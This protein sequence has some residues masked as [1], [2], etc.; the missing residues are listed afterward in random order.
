MIPS[1]CQYRSD[2]DGQSTCRLLADFF[3]TERRDLTECSFEMCQSCCK[4]RIPSP[5]ALNSSVASLLLLAS[6]KVIEEGGISTCDLTRAEHLQN[7]ALK[8]ITVVGESE[9]PSPSKKTNYQGSCFYLG[10]LLGERKCESCVGNIRQ[11]EFE[12]HHEG[13]ESTVIRDC[14]NCS[15]YEPGLGRGGINSWAVG[16]TTAPRREPNLP[17]MLQSLKKA[18]W[19]EARIFAEPGSEVVEEGGFTVTQRRETMGAWPNFMLGLSELVLSNPQADAYF[20]CQDDALFCGGL[21]KY[22]E[23]ELW[24]DDKVGVVSPHTPSHQTHEQEPGFF[25]ADV[26]WSSWGAMAFVFSNASARALLRHPAVINHRNRGMGDGLRNVDSV[27]GNWCRMAGLPYYLHAPSLCEHIGLT[28]TLWKVDSLEGRRSSSDFPGEDVDISTWMSEQLAGGDFEKAE[29]M[30]SNPGGLPRT[31]RSNLAIVAR[32]E[33]DDLSNFLASVEAQSVSPDECWMPGG[34]EQEM[35]RWYCPAKEM[36]IQRMLN[37][38]VS[39]WV[40]VL[41]S[42]VP[43]A[44]DQCRVPN[45]ENIGMVVRE[46]YCLVRRNAV[47]QAGGIEGEDLLG[48]IPKMR[49]LGWTVLDGEIGVCEIAAGLPEEIA[50][51][52]NLA[53]QDLKTEFILM[54]GDA[55]AE[56]SLERLEV[57]Q[58]YIDDGLKPGA[59]CGG[60]GT[61]VDRIPLEGALIERQALL[62]CF[63]FRGS[64]EDWISGELRRHGYT[65]WGDE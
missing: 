36:P 19:G 31:Q 42:L 50:A 20:M 34:D 9:N 65:L 60:G 52:M 24:L 63:P 38:I 51:S 5:K 22:L 26:G 33:V 29:A 40:M 57:F 7:W 16:V 43:L 53:L 46:G 25:E 48:I 3:E 64:L 37:R 2:P 28:T 41:N 47:L 17:E 44:A 55:E 27:V 1:D 23:N 58:R 18:G 13:H 30:K 62:N 4:S 10:E 21:R 6:G 14:M 49:A 39:D 45:D 8:N 12:C 61:K 56:H 54:G 35:P 15:D 11:K 32:G 59:V